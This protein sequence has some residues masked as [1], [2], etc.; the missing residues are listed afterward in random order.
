MTN[1]FSFKKDLWN[2]ITA[3]YP[4]LLTKATEHKLNT[5]TEYFY[6][7]VQPEFE[8]S[9]E[10]TNNIISLFSSKVWN[11]SDEEN[12][13]LPFETIT[14]LFIESIVTECSRNNFTE[15]KL[16]LMIKKLKDC[17]DQCP[18][19]LI[20]LEAKLRCDIIFP[21]VINTL[22]EKGCPEELAI[23]ITPSISEIEHR[24][25]LDAIECDLTTN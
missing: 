17:T 24:L 2:G 4:S 25:I 20:L 22:I 13:E 15:D 9:D 16:K 21:Y 8:L 7:E 10:L 3:N 11:H 19:S 12:Y 23:Q 18:K 14:V 6:D 1:L 5:C